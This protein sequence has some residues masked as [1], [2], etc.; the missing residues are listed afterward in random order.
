MEIL[1]KVFFFIVAIGVLVTVHEFGH[2][3]VARRA[4]IKVLRFSIGFG[5]P[6][7][8]WVRGED[9]TEYVIAAIPLGGYVKMVDTR[10]GDIAEQD[11]PRAFDKQSLAKR[12]AVVAAGPVFNFIFAILAYWLVFQIGETGARPLVG[13]LASN[14][15]AVE[16]GFM[17]GDEFVSISGEKTPTWGSVAQRIATTV[18]AGED[19]SIRVQGE[20]GFARDLMVNAA[21]FGE[22][23][24]NTDVL[25]TLGIEPAKPQIPAIVGEVI[26]NGPAEK[27][28]LQQGDVIKAIDGQPVEDWFA[29][30]KWV[31][32]NPDKEL[33]LNIQRDGSALALH[34]TPERVEQGGEVFGRVGLKAQAPSED[35]SRYR[36]EIILGPVDAL[37]GAVNRTA[38][39]SWLTLK[40]LGRMLIGEASVK[41][42]SG[43]LTIA[44]VAGQTASFGLVAFL[45]FLAI[46]SISLGV[47]NL[48]PV[49]MLDGGHLLYFAVEAVTGK[50]VSE[51]IQLRA[52]QIGIAVLASVM[53]LAFYVDFTRYFG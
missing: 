24:E 5:R 44:D 3:W 29:W 53:F 9:K 7:L 48:L 1:Q 39:Y 16:A 36:T 17:P 26:P 18:M 34:L 30:V 47:L 14:G 31:R 21:V 23:D 25:K 12:T 45:K 50:S 52:Q 40:V 19:L 33:S 28:G 10:E 38:E 4:G 42:L 32:D 8:S 46:V 2:Y 51:A 43:P 49:P 27:A 20:E 11:L 37:I 15:V 41:N 13:Q 35:L 6:L 22:F